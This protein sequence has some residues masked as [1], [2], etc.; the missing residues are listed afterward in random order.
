MLDRKPVDTVMDPNINLVF[1]QGEPLQDLRRY[2]RLVGRLNYFTIT[3]S[4]ISF[5]MIVVG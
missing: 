5:P 4:N 1:G 3:Q 2:R